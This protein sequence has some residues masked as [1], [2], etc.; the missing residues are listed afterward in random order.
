MK[1]A[2]NHCILPLLALLA[3]SGSV[4]A[5]TEYTTDGMPTALEEEIRWLH[6]RARF[7]T[8]AENA[9]RGTAYTDVPATTGPLTPHQSLTAAARNHTTDM[10]TLNVFQHGTI[11]GR[12]ITIP[13]PNPIFR[14]A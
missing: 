3:S 8:T 4:R 12:P 6:N 14:I 2:P 11:T 1:T 5:Q 13:P 10:A 7:D 9:L